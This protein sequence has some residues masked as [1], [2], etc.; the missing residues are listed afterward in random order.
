MIEIN[1]EPKI[2]V[3]SAISGTGKTCVEAELVNQVSNIERSISYT[4]RTKRDGEIEGSDYYFISESSFLDKLKQG[5]FIEHAVVHESYYGT[6]R[7]KVEESIRQGKFILLIIDTQGK[8]QIVQRLSN[9]TTIFIL[10]PS[11]QELYNRLKNRQSE[12][13][14]K[15]LIRLKNGYNEM[16]A[17]S[18]YDYAVVNNTVEQCS[19]DI[20]DILNKKDNAGNFEIGHQMSLVETLQKEYPTILKNLESKYKNCHKQNHI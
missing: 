3:V 12:S 2:I 16:M 9:V 5:E 13:Y 4:T 14:D 8:A 6:S 17:A 20:I 15:L 18:R 7:L 10:P 11:I 19:Q 1:T